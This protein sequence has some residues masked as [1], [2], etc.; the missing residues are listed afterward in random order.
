VR[1]A[2][3]RI[4]SPEDTLAISIGCSTEAIRKFAHPQIRTLLLTL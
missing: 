4:L 2:N 1:M 3:V